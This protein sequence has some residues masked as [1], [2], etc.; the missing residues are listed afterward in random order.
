MIGLSKLF[1]QLRR[2]PLSDAACKRLINHAEL[3]RETLLKLET[4]LDGKK[5]VRGKAIASRLHRLLYEVVANE[6]PGAGL[7]VTAF[8]GGTPKELER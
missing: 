2:P 6:G 8:S 1:K 5:D 4:H 7:D 3:V